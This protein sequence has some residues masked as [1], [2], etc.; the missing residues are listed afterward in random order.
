MTETVV[1]EITGQIGR[2]GS[3]KYPHMALATVERAM[4]GIAPPPHS[5]P[6]LIV[7]M[8]DYLFRIYHFLGE[9]EREEWKHP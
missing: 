4:E 6:E 9:P 1:Y 3:R 8:M 2:F 7:T 5:A